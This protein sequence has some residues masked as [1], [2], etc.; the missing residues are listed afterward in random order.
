MR[1][2]HPSAIRRRERAA[3]LQ[4]EEALLPGEAHP[5][6]VLQASIRLDGPDHPLFSH[7]GEYTETSR[8]WA[9][10]LAQILDLAQLPADMDWRSIV[11]DS[12]S[13]ARI[14]D[15]VS[16]TLKRQP[17]NGAKFRKALTHFCT[18]VK[19][20]AWR[21][22]CKS[23]VSAFT[24]FN[25][26][27]LGLSRRHRREL[28][29]SKAAREARKQ[30]TT[31]SV[32]DRREIQRISEAY[33]SSVL[34][35]PPVVPTRAL[36]IQFREILF[37]V[38]S[39]LSGYRTGAIVGTTLAEWQ[40]AE[41]SEDGQAFSWFT[42][43][44][45]TLG[46]YGAALVVVT[47]TIQEALTY[48]VQHLRHLIVTELPKNADSQRLL[49]AAR[50][51]TVV[52]DRALKAAADAVGGVA[53]DLVA[54]F[55]NSMN[56]AFHN[57]RE[58]REAGALTQSAETA[59]EVRNHSAHTAARDYSAHG[60]RQR[61]ISYSKEFRQVVMG[62]AAETARGPAEPLP[63]DGQCAGTARPSSDC[64]SSPPLASLLVESLRLATP[65]LTAQEPLRLPDGPVV[66]VEEATG[67]RVVEAVQPHYRRMRRTQF[68]LDEKEPY[69]PP[70]KGASA[71]SKFARWSPAELAILWWH[72]SVQS[73][74]V[75]SAGL[76]F[77]S[78]KALVLALRE[79]FGFR[80]SVQQLQRK[81]E[82]LGLPQL[83][84]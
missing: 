45:K 23:V 25:D 26:G 61:I 6:R 11:L 42:M 18:R 82:R 39:N 34:A 53:P 54:R 59:S 69:R 7:H 47:K 55:K 84:F 9:L 51:S 24:E 79:A 38:L 4:E 44:N 62:E 68:G 20:G 30:E 10:A 74:L 77:G 81:R 73:T 56:R 3:Q 60:R 50:T 28:H 65:E 75:S 70:T 17:Q 31:M 78:A 33:L 21:L 46:T 16:A 22:R 5:E 72:H 80:R 40:T 57:D 19:E 35:Q 36:A 58:M 43:A 27:L 64:A 12:A 41:M 66:D 13:L 32:E 48:F 63:E 83:K 71:A 76:P 29:L 1:C 52:L 8:Y 14:M 49:V 15:V 37:I 2:T 67:I